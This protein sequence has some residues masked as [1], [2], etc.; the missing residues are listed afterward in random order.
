[1][2]RKLGSD[3]FSLSCQVDDF[4][5]SRSTF[6]NQAVLE[7]KDQHQS[8]HESKVSRQGTME[9]VA[10]LLNEHQGKTLLRDR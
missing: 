9:M 2:A 1:M 7:V 3:V 5:E 6:R 4:L 10:A 8:R